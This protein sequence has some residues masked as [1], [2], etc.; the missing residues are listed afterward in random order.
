MSTTKVLHNSS[1][2]LFFALA[3]IYLVAAL[4]FRNG[5]ETSFMILL[6]RLLDIPFA[7][8]SLLYG[9]TGLYLQ[10]NEGRE[11]DDS[12]SIWSILIFATCIVLFGAVIFVNFAF[13][14]KL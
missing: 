11:D 9:G 6:M 5:I 1:A 2:N 10:L 4:G 8:I 7:F 14:S 13:P 3:L 12:G